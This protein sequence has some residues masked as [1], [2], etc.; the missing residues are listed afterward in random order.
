MQNVTDE[1]I[2]MEKR[3][4]EW[5]EYKLVLLIRDNDLTATLSKIY[6]HLRERALVASAPEVQDEI[7]TAVARE[8]RS[9]KQ[10]L[11]NMIDAFNSAEGDGLRSIEDL[12][13]LYAAALRGLSVLRPGSNLGIRPYGCSG[14][15][16]TNPLEGPDAADRATAFHQ[17][18]I[19]CEVTQPVWVKLSART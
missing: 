7:L 16:P 13:K 19:K 3:K 12:V 5:W 14:W 9:D 8:M 11:I 1:K 15:K 6:D 10:T 4:Y 18:P 17:R 2:L